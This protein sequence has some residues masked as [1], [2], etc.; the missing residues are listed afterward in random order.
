MAEINYST[1]SDNAILQKGRDEGRIIVT[2]D[3]DFATLLAL[4]RA[5]TPSVIRMRLQGLYGQKAAKLIREVSVALCRRL[6]ERGGGNCSIRADTNPSFAV[7][8]V[9][10]S[11]SPKIYGQ[12]KS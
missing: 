2:L 1:A 8:A 9:T 10:G 4:S 3:A 7:A 11:R 5:T 12:T 6:G